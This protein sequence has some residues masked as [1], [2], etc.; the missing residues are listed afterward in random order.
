VLQYF[1]T[2]LAGIAV[3]MLALR[4][5]QT[6]TQPSEV[7]EAAGGAANDGAKG[8]L[9]AKVPRLSA[10]WKSQSKSSNLPLIAAAIIL[11][12]ATGIFFFRSSASDNA[13]ATEL[14]PA[15]GSP[16]SGA[17]L[18]DVD[19]MIAQLAARLE[20]NPDDGEGF[21]MLGWSYLMTDK[22]QLALAPYQRALELLP[23]NASVHAG[24]GEVLVAIAA[25]T[26]TEE[27]KASFDR[28]IALDPIEPRARYFEGLWEEQHGRK[29]AALDAWVA[30]VGSEPADAPWQADVRGKIARL[31]DELGVDV[32]SALLPTSLATTAPTIAPQ[33]IEAAASLPEGQRQAM[34]DD[35]VE[36]LATRLRSNPADPDGW[37]R[38]VRSRMVMGQPQRAA[39]DLASARS[40]LAGNRNALTMLENLAAELGVPG[41]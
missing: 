39:T 7:A 13:E 15:A 33:T 27:A 2:A 30:L 32:S 3:G 37:A 34:V 5:F 16:Q 20:A 9:A 29:Q 31:A 8:W 18:S 36:G 23:D 21:R 19:T 38:L 22:P 6:S 10:L 4:M 11:A 25:G 40:A 24:H 26:V 17:A 14:T 41:N 12:V 1:L 35:M 28:A